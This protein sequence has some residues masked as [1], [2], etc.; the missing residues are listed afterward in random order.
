MGLAVSDTVGTGSGGGA[1]ATVT[2]AD[3][4]SLPPEP[5]Q[6]RE[7]LLLMVSAPVDSLPEVALGP[8]PHAPE[9]VQVVAFVEEQVSVEDS[10][11]STDVGFAASDTIGTGG[12][13]G[14]G[15]E[16]SVPP[17]PPP[18]QPANARTS[19]GTSSNLFMRNLKSSLL[20]RYGDVAKYV[21]SETPSYH[22]LIR[23]SSYPSGR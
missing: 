15:A 4:L 14:G 9:E 2:V 5:V 13:G 17:P 12:G 21:P 20:G 11:F 7:K 3:A 1:P 10:P 6:V 16:L 19:T 23:P 8:T 18:P 22:G